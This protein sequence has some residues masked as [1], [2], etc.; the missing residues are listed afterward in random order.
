MI[1][2]TIWPRRG[3]S[4]CFAIKR[5]AHP[6]FARKWSQVRWN[7]LADQSFSRH[8]ASPSALKELGLPILIAMYCRQASRA[9]ATRAC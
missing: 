7:R 5:G 1:E 3:A 2:K 9:V 6:S 8:I 4:G